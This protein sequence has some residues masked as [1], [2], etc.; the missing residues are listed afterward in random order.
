MSNSKLPVSAPWYSEGLKF[1][2]T[3]CGNCCTGFP[4]YT[5]V[6]EDEMVRLAEHLNMPLKEFV[7][8][9]LRR[10]QLSKNGEYRWALLEM[11]ENF[12]C[13]FLKDKK[14]SVY[15]ERPKQC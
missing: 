5:W 12:D 3:Q 14:C 13:I 2:C 15:Q 1:E 9:Y 11:T 10:V 6:S 7:H 4:G 8:K